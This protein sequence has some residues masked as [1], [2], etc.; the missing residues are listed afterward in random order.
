MSIT[1][2][3]DARPKFELGRIFATPSAVEALERARVTPE[4]LLARHAAGDWGIVNREDAA[5]NELALTRSLRL[6]SSYVVSAAGAQNGGDVIWI[7]TEAD[8]SATTLLLPGE[9]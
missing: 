9:Y 3:D 4:A 6:V 7:V 8:R 5:A 1:R 2:Q